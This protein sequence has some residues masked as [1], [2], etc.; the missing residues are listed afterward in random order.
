ML[1][2][3]L[4]VFNLLLIFQKHLTLPCL[5][6]YAFVSLCVRPAPYPL[7]PVGRHSVRFIDL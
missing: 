5:Q 3:R 2:I 4:F 6:K 1:P 7:E